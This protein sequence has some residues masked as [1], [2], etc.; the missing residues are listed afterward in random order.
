MLD[1]LIVSILGILNGKKIDLKDVPIIETKAI[2]N[3]YAR[4]DIRTQSNII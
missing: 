4:K 3:P 1:I 2:Q